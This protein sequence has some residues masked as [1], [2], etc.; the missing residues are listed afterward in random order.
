M[1]R[2]VSERL[3]QDREYLSNPPVLVP[4]ELGKLLFLYLSVLDNA[5]G[6]VFG[7]HDETRR[8]KQ[9]IYYLRKKCTPCEA[10]YTLIESTCCAL[11]WIP[12][13]TLHVSIHHTFNIP[14]GSTQKAIKGQALAYHLAE[15]PVDT[16]YE[17]LTTYFP[18]EEV[19]F[20]G[21]D[22]TE[23]YLVW[24]MFF[25]GATNFKGLGIGRVRSIFTQHQQR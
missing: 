25:D 18:D 4:L 16:D 13:K 15:Y 23:S 11:T 8:K 3:Q 6:C 1:D 22:I 20:A 5:F 21:E 14:A 10:K 2:R 24:R 17:P 12:Q 9:F 7:Q 19:L